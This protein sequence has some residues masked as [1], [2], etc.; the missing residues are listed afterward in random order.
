MNERPSR[1]DFDSMAHCYDQWYATLEGRVYDRLEQKA[2]S[3]YLPRNIEAMT[4]LEIGC[5]TGHWTRFF[6]DCGF[7]VT[8]IDVSE[9]MIEMAQGKSIT[10]ASFQIADGHSLPFNDDRFDI[11]VAITALEFVWNAEAVIEEMVRCTRSPGG[12]I[13]LGVL[14]AAAPINRKRQENSESL[15]AEARW[16]TSGQIKRLLRPF[17]HVEVVTTGF[18]S[19]WKPLLQLSPVFDVLGRLSRVP[20]GA[21]I[22]A[23]VTL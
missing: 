8:G 1:Y 9:A 14:N 23:K 15:F 6:S 11:T 19:H 21:F 4:L 17:G 3:R 20:Y 5:G 2:I 10:K 18:V 16:F 13:I 12:Q 22:V 7:E